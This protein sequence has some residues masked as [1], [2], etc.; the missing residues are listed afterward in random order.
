M[1]PLKTKITFF[2]RVTAILFFLLS[3]IVISVFAQE[4]DTIVTVRENPEK[5]L[6]KIDVRDIVK[7]GFNFWQDRFTGHWAGVDLGFNA[8]LNTDYSGYETEFMSNDILRSNSIYIN[9][10]QHSFS[11][12]HNRNTIGLVTGL[13]INF[14]NYRLDKNTTIERLKN[15]M[16]VPKQ[17]NYEENLKSKLSITS[18]SIPLLAEFQVPVNH[19]KNRIYFSGGGYIGYRI[20]SHT[21]IKYRAN[22]QKEKLKVPDHFSLNNFKYG[23]MFRAGYRWFNVFANYEITPLFVENRGPVLTPFTFG[24]T[25]LQF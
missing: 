9:L 12:Q 4:T 18:V 19:Y 10:I 1:K 11:L 23:L 5:I 7:N 16:I 13:G 15:D 24:F 14:Q 21:K 6:R 2:E 22:E 8:F 25:L 17:L 20:G 3:F